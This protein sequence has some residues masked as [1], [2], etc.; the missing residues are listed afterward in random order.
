MEK[1]I[2]KPPVPWL[3]GSRCP[4]GLSGFALVRTGR[5]GQ[6]DASTQLGS[7]EVNHA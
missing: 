1:E 5:S 4:L 7:L 6:T 2:R 3:L